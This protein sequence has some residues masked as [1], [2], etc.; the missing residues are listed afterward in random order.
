MGESRNMDGAFRIKE[1]NMAREK[2]GEP[3]FLGSD[4]E[5]KLYFSSGLC[6]SLVLNDDFKR[7]LVEVMLKKEIERAEIEERQ[8]AAEA[9]ERRA[10]AEAA[11][12]RAAEAEERLAAEAAKEE[13]LLREREESV[14]KFSNE[15]ESLARVR[16]ISLSSAIDFVLDKKFSNDPDNFDLNDYLSYELKKKASWEKWNYDKY[17]SRCG[18]CHG[19]DLN[20]I[21][22]LGVALRD[23]AFLENMTVEEII[24]FLKV[25]RMLNADD[26]ISGGVMPG[27]NWLEASE[28]EGIAR[29]IKLPIN[30]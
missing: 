10:A 12:R 16:N 29:Y 23:S 27:F 9:E 25:G 6:V 24:E 1:I 14:R 28:L 18:F 21:D 30:E 17:I 26:S 19:D 4:D 11:E 5:I 3:A 7:K 22:G 15:V 8:A 13:A 2:L 20:G